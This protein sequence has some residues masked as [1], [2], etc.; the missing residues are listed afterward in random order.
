MHCTLC[1][2]Y[3]LHWIDAHALYTVRGTCS[4][5]SESHR[6]CVTMRTNVHTH[7]HIHT[8]ARTHARTHTTL[9]TQIKPSTMVYSQHSAVKHSTAAAAAPHGTSLPS[10]H[11]HT[12]TDTR[13]APAMVRIGIPDTSTH[14][15]A[16]FCTDLVYCSSRY[17][18]CCI[19]TLSRMMAYTTSHAGRTQ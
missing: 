1:I 6:L 19:E 13:R 8:H 17:S 7:T 12:H 5:A 11:T 4:S 14:N 9:T 2:H 3:T 18:A 10:A 16:W 15:M